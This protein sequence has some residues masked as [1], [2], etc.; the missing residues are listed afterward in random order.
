MAIDISP[1]K[2]P[3]TAFWAT[4]DRDPGLDPVAK[5]FQTTHFGIL[6]DGPTT[7]RIKERDTLPVFTYYMGTYR[8]A[9]TRNFPHSAIVVSMDPARNEIYVAPFIRRRPEANLSS[10]RLPEDQIP[11]GY[12]MA[13]K[14]LDV[15]ERARIPWRGGRIVTQVILFDLAS[16]RI[17]T[18]LEAGIDTFVDAE[19]Q[20]FLEE[21]RANSDPQAPYPATHLPQSAT[22]LK[23]PPIPEEMGIALSAPRVAVLDGDNPLPLRVAF[24]LPA[25]PEEL[26]KP[27]HEE[28]NIHRKLIQRDGKIPYAACIGIHLV[29]VGS[30]KTTPFVYKLQFPVASVTGTDEK[31]TASGEFCIDLRKLEQF[32][33]FDQTLVLYAYAQEWAS[34]PAMI[35]LIDQSTK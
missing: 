30:A 23:P 22:D 2:L 28:A 10:K 4:D 26:V 17:E 3:D 32:P 29:A 5:A 34:E 13:F 35:G 11:K 31:K 1:V 12:A 16:N 14:S 6:I 15:R 18:R 7:V 27:D 25:L 24:R 33:A 8:Q 21:M 19:K 20:K 9:A